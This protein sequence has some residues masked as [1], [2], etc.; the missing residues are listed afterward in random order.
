[1]ISRLAIAGSAL[2]VVAGLCAASAS[3][4]GR[5]TRGSSAGPRPRP[6]AG[7]ISGARF[8]HRS[9]RRFY[10]AAYA[11][12]PY[13]YG[14][15]EYE[16]LPQALPAPPN[17]AQPPEPAAPPRVIEPLLLEI[18]NGEW[19]RVPNSSQLSVAPS[20]K[21]DTSAVPSSVRPVALEPAGA[22][23]PLP[24]L[25]PAV[26]VYRDGRTEEIGKYMIEG[27]ALYTNADYWSTG[28]W[29][30]KIPLAQVDIPAS[31]KLNQER[32]SK[33]SLPSRPNEIVV[34]F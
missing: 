18:Q 23:V 11:Y 19:V 29:S 7:R 17:L 4:Q 13:F 20:E 26:L 14:D 25:P 21:T 6:A 24:A 2:L 5:G 9:A 12:P 10:G 33:F 3:A 22:A 30:R 15:D 27:D 34:R 32:G 8:T 31:L 1:M 16:D 28:S